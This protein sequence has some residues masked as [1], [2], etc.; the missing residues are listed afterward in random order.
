MIS[1]LFS[2]IWGGYFCE[3]CAQ[4]WS[5]AVYRTSAVLSVC[6]EKDRG[7]L[8]L[9]L[10]LRIL[11]WLHKKEYRGEWRS[12]EYGTASIDAC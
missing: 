2:E 9:T 5:K 7:N 3:N 10:L 6:L 12:K 4:L 8:H 1:H 11:L